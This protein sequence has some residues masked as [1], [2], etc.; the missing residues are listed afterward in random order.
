[1]L[2]FLHRETEVFRHKSQ[3]IKQKFEI[4]GILSL[5]E[6]IYPVTNTINIIKIFLANIAPFS[7][8]KGDDTT[9]DYVERG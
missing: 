3:C 2:R 9:D 4:D 8:L 6:R 5:T 1:M 7:R